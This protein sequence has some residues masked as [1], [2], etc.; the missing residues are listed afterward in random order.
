MFTG[1]RDLARGF[2]SSPV[3]VSGYDQLHEVDWRGP[4]APFSAR[5]VCS[6][7]SFSFVVWFDSPVKPSGLETLFWGAP[8]ALIHSLY[9]HSLLHSVFH[10]GPIVVVCFFSESGPFC[11]SCQIY[12]QPGGFNKDSI[13]FRGS[14]DVC[15]ACEFSCV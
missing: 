2:P 1:L 15:R 9:C 11:L 12:S 8:K 5:R 3:L 13:L 4:L 6:R 7:P 14:S 10:G